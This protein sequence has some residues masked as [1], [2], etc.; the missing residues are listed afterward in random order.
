MD[1]IKALDFC[2]NLKEFALTHDSSTKFVSVESSIFLKQMTRRVTGPFF[3]QPLSRGKWSTI[4]TTFFVGVASWSA[5]KQLRCVLED[6]PQLMTLHIDV[7]AED[8][9]PEDEIVRAPATL[10]AVKSLDVSAQH[11][12]PLC[13]LKGVFY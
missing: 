9:V 6:M 4:I 10:H 2:K 8:N 1:V 12:V 13:F 7:E 11:R 3:P 5:W